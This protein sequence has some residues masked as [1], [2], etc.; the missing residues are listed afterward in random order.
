M[1]PNAVWHRE[2]R[3]PA[4]PTRLQRIEWHAEH[5]VACGCRPVPADLAAEVKALRRRTVRT[6]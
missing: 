4:S 3:M 5:S 2:N 6:N 1:K